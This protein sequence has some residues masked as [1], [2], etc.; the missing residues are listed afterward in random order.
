MDYDAWLRSHDLDKL[1]WHWD[2]WYKITW[3]D[4]KFRAARLDNQ[5]TLAADT[6]AEL[7]LLLIDDYATD[8]VA[9]K[10]PPRL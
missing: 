1:R 8:P 2:D 7:R 3:D 9:R 10:C 5:R 4:G 6:A